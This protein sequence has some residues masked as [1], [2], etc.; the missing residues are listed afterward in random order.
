[1][2]VSPQ[3]VGSALRLVSEGSGIVGHLAVVRELVIV[4]K[5]NKTCIWCQKYRECKKKR[6]TV[7]FPH[8]II[9]HF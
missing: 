1:M 5:Q 9:Y 2:A 6:T 8:T 3:P 7:T 4:G